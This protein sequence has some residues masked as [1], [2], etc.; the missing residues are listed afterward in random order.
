[1]KID[2]IEI[3]QLK[4]KLKE[5]FV[6]SLG[7]MNHAEN[8]IVIIRTD[9]GINGFGECSPFATIN[10]E[11]IETCFVVGQL[12][13]KYLIGKNLL[14]I[15]ACMKAMDK[16]IYGNTS[17]KSAFDIALHDIASQQS[18]VPLYKFLGGKNN[19]VISTDYTVS[20]GDANKM[21]DDSMKIKAAGY[22]AIKVKLGGTKEE[23]T[24]RV[25]RIREKAGIEIPLRIDANQ[26]W[27]AETA[28]EILNELL[29]FN[30]QFCEEPIPRWDFMNLPKVKKR[31]PIPVMADE[32]CFDHHDAERL[33]D[34]QACD[35]IN[36][37]L[38][39][40]SGITKAMK[41]IRL[42]EQAG[43]KMQVGGFLESRLGF[44]ASAHL[45]L[46]SDNIQYYDFDTPLMFIEDPVERGIVYKAQGIVEVPPMN[47]LGATINEV[48]LQN[49]P[50]IIV[51]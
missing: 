10:G 34:L 11:T 23:D 48:R 31:S 35:L 32:S 49:L 38:G 6:T 28:I 39:K 18:G 51:K 3:F 14:E 44:T 50:K 4:V 5:P 30:I 12:L 21:A 17:I 15:E 2:Q 19:K 7:R 27:D 41:I 47:G 9:E 8:V 22:P 13:A 45:A 1:M 46:C 25:K 29:S 16:I 24:E 37:K 40:S 33:I 26:G 43:M 42:A 36:I 20:I